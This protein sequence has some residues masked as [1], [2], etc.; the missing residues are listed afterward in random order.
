ML[1]AENY[2]ED[3]LKVSLLHKLNRLRYD[4][5]FPSIALNICTSVNSARQPPNIKR[6]TIR[7][8][9]ISFTNVALKGG[10][11]ASLINIFRAVGKVLID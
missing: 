9:S 10:V 8:H 2:A 5:V 1:T 3:H 11:N 7:E 6:S 4:V